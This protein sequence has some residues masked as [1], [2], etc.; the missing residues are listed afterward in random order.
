MNQKISNL[1]N[2]YNQYN[3]ALLRLLKIIIDNAHK[4]GIW[5][6]MCGEVAG[7][8]NMIPILIGMGLNEFSMSA[9]CIPKARYIIN[10]INKEEMERY[11]DTITNLSTAE[12]IKKFIQEKITNK[13]N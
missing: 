7:D 10:S 5:V 1:Y 11:I 13:I 8:P 4:E 3:P 6:G 2:Q 12:E 9:S